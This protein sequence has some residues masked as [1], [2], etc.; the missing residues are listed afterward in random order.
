MHYY[1]FCMYGCFLYF[2]FPACMPGHHKLAWCPLRQDEGIGIPGTG[3]TNNC[4]WA[5]VWMLGTEHGSSG[6]TPNALNHKAICPVP[7]ALPFFGY[8]MIK[9]AVLLVVQP[10]LLCC[11]TTDLK[12]RRQSTM[13]W[14]LQHHEPITIFVLTSEFPQLFYSS[15]REI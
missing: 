10:S 14:N 2:V 4:L 13:D 12:Q 15:K 7:R 6:R 8:Q 3:V 11:R 9:E 1:L 5:T